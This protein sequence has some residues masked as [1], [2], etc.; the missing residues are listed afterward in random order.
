MVT[1][2][3]AEA[4]LR[5]A[6]RRWPAPI[7]D[8]LHREWAA[9]LHVLGE[10]G[11]P[12]AM[13]RY[14]GSLALAR[15]ARQ[16]MSAAM[17]LRQLWHAVRLVL[18]APVI[19]FVL[20]AASV[21][22]MSVVVHRIPY[23][24]GAFDPMDLQM[25][26]ITGLCVLGA[27]L[28]ALLGRRWSLPDRPATLVAAVTVPP[29]AICLLFYA[30]S[31]NT[32]KIRLHGPAYLLYFGGLALLLAWAGHRAR[33]GRRRSARW[34]AIAG[35][36]VLADVATMVPVLNSAQHPDPQ[37]APLWLFVVLT[38]QNLGIP[39][40]PDAFL[41]GDIAEFDP[42]LYLVFTGFAIGAALGRR[43]APAGATVEATPGGRVA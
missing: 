17:R 28:L 25:P 29:L 11:R 31:N 3:L 7:R 13:L 34:L 36:V 33:A 30:V 40:W 10:A 12:W 42:V 1:A 41:V 8:E 43:P 39:A 27:L 14:S 15:P 18:L 16:P 26:M 6:A 38:G 9:E 21:V 37:G 32:D 24:S 2:R 5:A 20:L 35:A 4:L 22:V 19:G 23:G